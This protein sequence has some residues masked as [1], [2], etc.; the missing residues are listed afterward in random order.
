[1]PASELSI[2]VLSDIHFGSHA[3]HP[4]FAPPGAELSG[5]VQYPISMK[6]HLLET[7]LSAGVQIHAIF[8]PGDITSAACPN[9][10]EAC[11]AIIKEYGTALEV[12]AERIFHTYGNHDSN[13]RISS[14][15]DGDA[16]FKPDDQYR[17]IASS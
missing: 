3:E 6:Q 17:D 2:L 5:H 10:F 1:M 7:I 13:W 12:P 8:V 9:E 14:L 11:W 15:A 16:K 4:D